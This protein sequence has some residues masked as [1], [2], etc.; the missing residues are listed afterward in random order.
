MNASVASMGGGSAAI[1]E[2]PGL[3]QFMEAYCEML[4]KYEQ[5]LCKPFKEAM[6]F[7][8]RIESQFKALTTSSSDSGK[9]L[10]YMSSSI[11]PDLCFT[12][13]EL[14]FFKYLK[15]INFT[16]VYLKKKILNLI[17]NSTFGF[18]YM[19]NVYTY[20]IFC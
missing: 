1:G 8:S 18:A 5:E 17:Y 3:D 11:V 6:L 14:H 2:D 19:L 10:L 12:V 9:S 15:Q 20:K 16:R 13:I 7:F 4:S